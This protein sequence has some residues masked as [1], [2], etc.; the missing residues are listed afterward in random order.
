MK[1][2]EFEILKGLEDEIAYGQFLTCMYV[3]E[4]KTSDL[5]PEY[6]KAGIKKVSY[7]QTRL[8]K[9]SYLEMVNTSTG[10]INA[11]V[12]F[13]AV[14]KPTYNSVALNGFLSELIS[15]NEKKYMIL[16][17]RKSDT[18]F[19]HVKYVDGNGV[20]Y[21]AED[22]LREKPV[23]ERQAAIDAITG[24]EKPEVRNYAIEKIAYLAIGGH[25]FIDHDVIAEIEKLMA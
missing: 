19:A 24:E 22:I 3:S 4:P 5:N 17:F 18:T 21:K 11:G 14:R 2:N 9:K 1:R 25:K 13:K 8:F 23:S 6:K 20:E 10:A 7:F 15:D 16:K 12:E